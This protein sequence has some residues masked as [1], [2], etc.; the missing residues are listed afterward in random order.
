MIYLS[1]FTAA[2]KIHL[3]LLLLLLQLQNQNGLL[4]FFNKLLLLLLLHNR[5]STAMQIN[6]L[7]EP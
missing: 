1:F 5:F 7:A 2:R 4:L 3:E 6:P